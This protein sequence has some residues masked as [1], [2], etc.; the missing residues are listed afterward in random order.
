MVLLFTERIIIFLA[1]MLGLGAQLD[2]SIFYIK[3][4]T[5]ASLSY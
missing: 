2:Y 1:K 5:L 4:K 3:R